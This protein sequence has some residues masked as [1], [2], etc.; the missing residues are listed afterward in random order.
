M[1]SEPASK[2]MFLFSCG[3]V[4]LQVPGR[5]SCAYAYEDI[6]AVLSVMATCPYFLFFCRG[7]LQCN[8][9]SLG[10]WPYLKYLRELSCRQLHYW[11]WLIRE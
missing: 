2:G 6:L 1:Q 3:M 4:I 9:L 11:E 7:K 5:V 10:F 8:K